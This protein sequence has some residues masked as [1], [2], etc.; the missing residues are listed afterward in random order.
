MC[1]C[2]GQ[3][4][5]NQFVCLFPIVLVIGFDPATCTV[6]EGTPTVDLVVSVLN[7]TLNRTVIVTLTL[8]DGTATGKDSNI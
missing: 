3:C 6:T 7:G 1:A 2:I 5:H 4:S 8:K